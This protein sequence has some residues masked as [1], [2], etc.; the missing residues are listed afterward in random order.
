MSLTQRKFQDP[1][2]EVIETRVPSRPE[3][4][5]IDSKEELR[6]EE[7]PIVSP[8][9][10]DIDQISSKEPTTLKNSLTRKFLDQSALSGTTQK[11]FADVKVM[12]SPMKVFVG[13]GVVDRVTSRSNLH[14]PAE[15]SFANRRLSTNKKYPFFR[16]DCESLAR[17]KIRLRE[18][19]N[20]VTVVNPPV[21]KLPAKERLEF[22]AA[23]R[24]NQAHKHKPTLTDEELKLPLIRPSVRPTPGLNVML[25]PRVHSSSVS[26]LI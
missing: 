25:S 4:R 18:K 26:S 3:I 19:R 6:A 21:I 9:S 14:L 13:K 5:E 11:T 1:T 8:P 20:T 15:P 2:T 12:F 16:A 10:P 17:A 23:E 7:P 22:R 24:L